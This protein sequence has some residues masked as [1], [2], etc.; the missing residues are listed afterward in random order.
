MSALV[1]KAMLNTDYGIVNQGLFG[2]AAIGWLDG[3][4]IAKASILLVNLWLGYPY[5][6]LVATGALQSISGDI[7]E[8]ARVDG[9]SPWQTF[10]SITLPLVFVATAPLLISSFAFNFNNFNLIFMLTG[11]GPRPDTS[12]TA[13]GQTDILIS[14][15]YRVSGLDG[16]G[17]QNFGL[18]TALS[19]IIFVIVGAISVYSFRRTRR[20]EEL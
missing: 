3:P 9:A 14:M 6:F 12:P 4:W 18:A 17:S 8:S 7:M 16:S 1:W 19:I 5:M 10:K 20:L 15:V 13:P 11:G 2:G